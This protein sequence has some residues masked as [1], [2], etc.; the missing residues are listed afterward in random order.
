MVSLPYHDLAPAPEVGAPARCR[1]RKIPST[2]APLQHNAVIR[3]TKTYRYFA[4]R[5]EF[6]LSPNTH[7]QKFDGGSLRHVVAAMNGQGLRC[8]RN[9]SGSGVA[10][11]G[12]P[13]RFSNVRNAPFTNWRATCNAVHTAWQRP[14][15]IVL[16][17][18][19]AHSVVDMRST[20]HLQSQRA[21]S[22]SSPPRRVR[23]EYSGGI[24]Q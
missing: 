8:K 19:S 14:P 24:P 10:A 4:R 16:P 22:P 9:I 18:G 13:F 12:P 7:Q 6:I 21:Q 3:K 1:C 17:V 2:K 5:H 20:L 11:T 23:H 15:G